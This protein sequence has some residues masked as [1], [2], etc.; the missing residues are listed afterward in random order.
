M[1]PASNEEQFKFLIS[2][3]RQVAKECNIVTKGAA[4]KRYERMMRSHGIAPNAASIKP[5][6]SSSSS[7]SAPSSTSRN[8]SSASKKRKFAP[9]E[10]NIDDD[11]EEP[12]NQKTSK[13]RVKRE[14]KREMGARV[15][16]NLG[17]VKEEGYRED[18]PSAQLQEGLQKGLGAGLCDINRELV[19]YYSGGSSSAGGSV[20]GDVQGG[21]F[22]E[23]DAYAGD[24]GTGGMNAGGMNASGMNASGMNTCRQRQS[25]FDFHVGG[26]GG[27]M[28]A[29]GMRGNGNRIGGH[30][31]QDMMTSTPKSRAATSGGMGMDAQ[32]YKSLGKG[33]DNQ[34]GSD[35]PLLVE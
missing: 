25:G 9:E 12:S 19:G 24:M 13:S 7:S 8:K 35:S 21:E 31:E 3:I 4:A 26:Y 10:E 34:G 6:P 29:Q 23:V 14:V 20:N 32:E 22:G 15:N 1:A 18:S 5:A 17:I 33:Y 28:G 11:E 30:C 27:M 2:C 16:D